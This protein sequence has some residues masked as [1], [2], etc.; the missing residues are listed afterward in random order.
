MPLLGAQVETTYQSMASRMLLQDSITSTDADA[1]TLKNVVN[2]KMNFNTSAESAT[3]ATITEFESV[4]TGGQLQVM[5]SAWSSLDARTA[6][7]HLLM[8]R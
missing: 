3:S 6:I 7:V 2:V 1:S 5:S 4:I 8:V